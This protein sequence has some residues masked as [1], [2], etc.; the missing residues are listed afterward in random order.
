MLMD[1]GRTNLLELR[2]ENE[3]KYL[4]VFW[5]RFDLHIFKVNFFESISNMG[6]NSASYSIALVYE[7]IYISTYQFNNIRSEKI[8]KNKLSKTKS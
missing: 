8:K 6:N 2:E 4:Y 1:D 5:W 3:K 7:N